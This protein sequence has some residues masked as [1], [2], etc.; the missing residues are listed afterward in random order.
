MS[1]NIEFIAEG[2]LDC[3]LLLICG[4]DIAVIGRLAA[5]FQQ[6]ADGA[7]GRVAVHELAGLNAVGE[8]CLTALVSDRDEGVVPLAPGVL[9]WRLTAASWDNVVG[10]LEP[11]ES[12]SSEEHAHQYIEQSGDISVIVSTDRSW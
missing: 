11:L 12:R 10:L 1:M 8:I 3:P 2:G 9:Q 6:L 7:V 5:E 4:R